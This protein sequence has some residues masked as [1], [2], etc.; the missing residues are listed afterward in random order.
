[1]FSKEIFTLL[2]A[3]EQMG[4]L[5]RAKLTGTVFKLFS[6]S[7]FPSDSIDLPIDKVVNL[8]A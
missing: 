6:E 7:A 4:I 2:R 3:L 5:E 1:L 8:T